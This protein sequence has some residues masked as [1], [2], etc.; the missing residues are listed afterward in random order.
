MFWKDTRAEVGGW[1][2]GVQGPALG[3]RLQGREFWGLT[4]GGVHN[5]C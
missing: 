3:I 1:G 2:A 4:G 5:S